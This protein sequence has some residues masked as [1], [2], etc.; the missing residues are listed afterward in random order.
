M[1]TPTSLHEDDKDW[2]NG[3]C[4]V[5]A[6][7]D[8]TGGELMFPELNLS[9]IIKPGDVILFRSWILYH[10]AGIVTSGLSIYSF[11]QSQYCDFVC[12]ISSTMERGC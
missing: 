4:A 7:G 9:F 10:G 3:F 2:R 12:K 11:H 6:L 1:T 5:T 8:F